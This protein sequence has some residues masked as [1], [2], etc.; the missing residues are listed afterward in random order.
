MSI[1]NLN[2]IICIDI[3]S[4]CWNRGEEPKGEVSEIIEI[5]LAIINLHNLEIEETNSIIVKPTRSKISKFCTELTTITQEKVDKGVSFQFACS[6][7]EDHYNSKNVAW[8]SWG[9]YDRKMFE[10]QCR[11]T[12]VNYPFSREHINLKNVFAITHGLSRELNMPA[13][14]DYLNMPL[15]GTLHVGVDD[16]INIANIFIY[17][18]KKVRGIK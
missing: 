1:K 3:E 18:N 7:L 12:Y 6:F 15:K 8:F 9:E 17:L 13:A 4:S 16:A 11:E 5:G 10:S 14:L 2:K